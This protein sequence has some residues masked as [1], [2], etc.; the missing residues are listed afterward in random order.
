MC[1]SITLWSTLLLSLKQLLSNVEMLWMKNVIKVQI[2]QFQYMFLTAVWLQDFI[3]CY[4]GYLCNSDWTHSFLYFSGHKQRA[5]FLY[6]I[7]HSQC[8]LEFSPH[9][10]RFSDR[11]N[12]TWMLG[13]GKLSLHK[14]QLQYLTPFSGPFVGVLLSESKIFVDC[15]AIIQDQHT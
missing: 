7:Q 1:L 13:L 11:C 8:C 4:V 15:M 6:C 5:L 9:G 10:L 14:G 12:K 3:Y 2:R